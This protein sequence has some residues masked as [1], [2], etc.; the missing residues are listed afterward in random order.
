VVISS[1]VFGLWHIGPTTV[2]L[3]MNEVPMG[4]GGIGAVAGAVA[5]TTVAGVLFCLLRILTGGILAPVLVHIATN[6]LGTLAA[7]YAQRAG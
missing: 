2:A 1:V 6:S 3:Q 4:A 7:F 5:L